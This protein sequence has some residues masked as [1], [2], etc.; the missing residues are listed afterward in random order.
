MSTGLSA[1]GDADRERWSRD[2]GRL[3]G[4]L[5]LPVV[6]S[7]ARALEGAKGP[8]RAEAVLLDAHPVAGMAPR[9]SAL[10]RLWRQ[11]PHLSGEALGLALLSAAA[12]ADRTEQ[13]R[14]TLVASGPVA[15]TGSGSGP[16]RDTPAR[17]TAAVLEEVLRG[18]CERLLVVGYAHHPSSGAVGEL[19][20]AAE[21]GVVVDVVLEEKTGAL[22]TFQKHF[23][24]QPQ[25]RLW[26][27][28]E[29]HRGAEGKASLHA[30]LIAADTNKALVGSANLTGHALRHNIEVGV[31][32][33]DPFQVKRLVGHFRFLM[34]PEG[35]LERV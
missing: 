9:A 2:L 5:P 21:R 7:W 24:E 27:W 18:A 26:R 30:K 35:P 3:A 14:S 1:A 33:R 31:L 15:R 8:G 29:E 12:V 4:R 19:S 22:G 23:S 20:A 13:E 34:G 28:P 6:Q 17:M 16:G 25:V 32:V 11:R 10:A